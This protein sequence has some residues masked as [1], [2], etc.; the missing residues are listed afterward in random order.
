MKIF[1]W[2][3][4]ATD[5]ASLYVPA[6]ATSPFSDRLLEDGGNGGL[7][8]SKVGGRT[9]Y[10]PSWPPL[11]TVQLAPFSH[12]PPLGHSGGKGKRGEEGGI[13]AAGNQVNL[14]EAHAFVFQH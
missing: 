13:V 9:E 2:I 12:F 11:L 4:P 10:V 6:P 8:S 7:L 14:L 1:P 5:L 3:F